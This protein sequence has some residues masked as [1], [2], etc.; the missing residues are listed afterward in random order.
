MYIYIYSNEY[1][2]PKRVTKI[3]FL[4]SNPVGEALAHAAR[5]TDELTESR[6]RS[7]AE[8]TLRAPECRESTENP[9]ARRDSRGIP[10]HGTHRLRHG[11][12]CI[13]VHHLAPPPA[14]IKKASVGQALNPKA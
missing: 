14:A 4:N 2:F 1:G 10:H 11:E 7:A 6:H 5:C 3:K 12:A 8:S 9:H 13:L